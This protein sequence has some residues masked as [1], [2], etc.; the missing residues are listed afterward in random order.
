MISGSLDKVYHIRSM[1]ML[2]IQILQRR[3][4][5]LI[6][7]VDTYQIN[8]L[9]WVFQNLLVFPNSYLNER[10]RYVEF[11][12]LKSLKYFTN[13]GIPQGSNLGSLLFILFINVITDSLKYS[14]F[15]I[16]ADDLE[17]YPEIKLIEYIKILLKFYT[18]MVK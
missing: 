17:L 18:N 10:P 15:L 12:K 11:L 1:L 7:K 8:Y 13:S 4:K 5:K 6:I 2:Y 9:V 3:L 16:L 14:K